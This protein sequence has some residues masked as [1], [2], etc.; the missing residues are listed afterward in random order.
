MAG[1]ILS[2]CWHDTRDSQVKQI[3]RARLTFERSLLGLLQQLG[4][5]LVALILMNMRNNKKVEPFHFGKPADL[6]RPNIYT[7]KPQS[8]S[9]VGIY[10]A[11]WEAE[12]SGES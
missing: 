9:K 11:N 3:R 10:Q 7:P 12:R 4:Y 6:S 8:I 5:V 2:L 1:R